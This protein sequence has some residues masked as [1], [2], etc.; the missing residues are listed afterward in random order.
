MN[1]TEIENCIEN[2]IEWKKI[3]LS[4]LD[5]AQRVEYYRL[6]AFVKAT[7]HQ[8][9]QIINM[10]PDG[11]IAK[12]L[13]EFTNQHST[14]KRFA[15]LQIE[16]DLHSANVSISTISKFRLN[17]SNLERFEKADLAENQLKISELRLK[18]NL[19]D[20]KITHC[21]LQQITNHEVEGLPAE[22]YQII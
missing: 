15:I 19:Y 18:S 9:E 17:D 1:I 16:K 21:I 3:A 20:F 10:Q 14:D 7:K 12:I 13:D 2:C 11:F 6:F 22:I 5:T 8:Y 4:K